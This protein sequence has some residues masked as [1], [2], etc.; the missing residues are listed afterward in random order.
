[1]SRRPVKA[2]TASAAPATMTSTASARTRRRRAGDSA[3]NIQPL[4]L[5]A[6]TRAACCTGSHTDENGGA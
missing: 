5:V 3:P 1:V 2:K 4:S 6:A